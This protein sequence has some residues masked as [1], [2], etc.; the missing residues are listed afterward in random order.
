MTSPCRHV[1]RAFTLVELLVV[2]A[3][4]AILIGVLLPA[5]AGARASGYQIKD[6]ANQKQF[7]VGMSAW[8]NDHDLQ[9]PGLN[10]S[11]LRL[12]TL[13]TDPSKLDRASKPV[14]NFDW[15]S[16]ALDDTQ[17]PEDR[18]ERFAFILNE[19]TNPASSRTLSSQDLD[20]TES[21]G[22]MQDFMEGSGDYSG[23][24]AQ[25]IAAPTYFM[26]AT[27]QWAG[28]SQKG[29]TNS[30]EN[31]RYVQ[32][33]ADQGVALLPP[34]WFPRVTNVGLPSNKVGISDGSFDVTGQDKL[35]V[36]IWIEPKD[37]RYGAFCTSTPC[38]KDS[39]NF[40]TDTQASDLELSYPHT[41]RMNAGYWD[42]H[43][44]T[45]TP[46]NSQDPGLWYPRGSEWEGSNATDNANKLYNAGDIIN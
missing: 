41:G 46:S 22:T 26:A 43:V 32:P 45:L 1:R 31:E 30:V 15:L 18:N 21:P 33:E 37:R 36:G 11:G 42:G 19:Y 44:S 23:K 35:P 28:P 24:G 7:L 13:K 27:W 25:T 12:N 5:L 8:S 6:A 9:I 2:I 16:Q 3:I 17:L 20:Y 14:Q 40:V 10:T 34:S 4:I 39:K 38:M 29:D